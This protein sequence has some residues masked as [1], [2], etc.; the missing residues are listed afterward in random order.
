MKFIKLLILKGLFVAFISVL[1]INANAQIEMNLEGCDT[2]NVDRPIYIN[3]ADTTV[4]G[5]TV[6]MVFTDSLSVFFSDSLT[7]AWDNQDIHNR[8]YDFTNKKDTT[9]IVL[10]DPTQNR[11]FCQPYKGRVTS[12]FGYRRWQFHYGT[13]VKLW[14]GDT[15][16]AAF[17]GVIRISKYSKSY[18]NV[19]VIRHYNGLETLYAHFSERLVPCNKIVKAGEPIGL[20]GNTGKSYGSHL[21]FEVRFL[22]EPLNPND[23]IDFQ[24]FKVQSDTFFLTKKNFEYLVELRKA[25]FH[26]IRKGDNLGKIARKYGTTVNALCKLNGISRKKVLRPGRKIRYR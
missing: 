22:G 20:G 6:M 24:N 11:F 15:V 12:D 21:H 5:D 18:G 13:D 10:V 26:T 9:I 7:Q 16:Y 14:K 3:M 17:D 8:K 2:L 25:R 23:I 4:N 19:V 1:S